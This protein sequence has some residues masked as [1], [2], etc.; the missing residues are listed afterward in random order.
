VYTSR[1]SFINANL[2][3][4]L[5]NGAEPSLEGGGSHSY[6]VSRRG[7]MINPVNNCSGGDV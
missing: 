6:F 4:Y 3:V 5:S 1:V 7:L 2:I